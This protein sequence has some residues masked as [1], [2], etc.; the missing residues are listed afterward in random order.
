MVLLS[1][2]CP[3]PVRPAAP[4]RR[5]AFPGAGVVVRVFRRGAVVPIRSLRTDTRGRFAF[6]L[7][8]GAY[9]LRVVVARVREEK[10]TT[11]VVRQAAWTSL[12][13]YYLVSPYME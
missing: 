4:P 13:L 9:V 5:C 6:R 7:P 8:A 11:V 1:H 10:P 2:G 12:S 3:G